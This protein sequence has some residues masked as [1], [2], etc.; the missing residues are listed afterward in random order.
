MNSR[1]TAALL[2]IQR[3]RRSVHCAILQTHGGPSG[4]RY[5]EW[6]HALVLAQTT[7]VQWRCHVDS[8]GTC[9]KSVL[10]QEV[11]NLLAKCAI[12]VVPSSE[13]ER[14]W[15]LQLLLCLSKERWHSSSDP[16]P[17]TH[18]P[19]II[20]MHI[21]NDNA[22]KDPRADSEIGDGAITVPRTRCSRSYQWSEPCDIQCYRV[23]A[24]TLLQHRMGGTQA[25]VYTCIYMH[26]EVTDN[27]LDFFNA[28]AQRLSQQ[29]DLVLD[30]DSE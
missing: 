12:E 27:F 17:E 26:F 1:H 11:L 8:T 2:R 10:R 13:R 15:V 3:A 23:C 19:C 4:E 7:P 25:G 24:V 16:R 29:V 9:R 20:Q 21:Q 18:Q 30:M 28:M 5:R 14:E 6:L 22:E